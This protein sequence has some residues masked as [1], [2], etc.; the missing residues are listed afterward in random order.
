M[1]NASTLPLPERRVRPR[2]AARVSPPVAVRSTAGERTEQDLKRLSDGLLRILES[3][4]ARVAEALSVE[5]SSVMTMARYLIEDAAQR[6]ARGELEEASEA[7]QNAGARIRDATHQ[8]VSLSSDL[9][10]RI[11]DDLGL[12]AA[13]AWYFRDFGQQNRT[14]FVSPR[15]TV[16]EAD[17]P[18]ELK[19]TVFRILQE[20]LSNVARHSHASAV[21]IFLSTYEGELRLRIEDN[22]VGFDMERWRFRRHGYEGFGL[23][24]IFWWVETTNGA[25]TI[26]AVPRHGARIQVSWMLQSRQESPSPSAAPAEA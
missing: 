20:A 23:G 18:Q 8:L 4:R 6:L 24:M 13:L 19:L 17:V 12:L 15:I 2:P 14:I 9:R 7:L 21:R 25:C 1:Y 5:L 16:T 26:E 22:G 3:D 11:L 10:P